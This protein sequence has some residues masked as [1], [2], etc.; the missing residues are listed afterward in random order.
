MFSLCIILKGMYH[1]VY[2]EFLYPSPWC[3]QAH[4]PCLRVLHLVSLRW[5]KFRY[6][7]DILLTNPRLANSNMGNV[8]P[9]LQ[10]GEGAEGSDRC[11]VW[12]S[13]FEQWSASGW[14]LGVLSWRAKDGLVPDGPMSSL[15]VTRI[16]GR[17][18]IT[19]G[20]APVGPSGV[21]VGFV[22]RSVR[23][24]LHVTYVKKLMISLPPIK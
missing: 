1:W 9:F 2:I 20:G 4:G 24:R 17:V 10:E 23:R 16:I 12:L 6:A 3:D 21:G 7:M 8:D 19:L 22:D 18:V 5:G 13:L 15:L 14:F 11:Q